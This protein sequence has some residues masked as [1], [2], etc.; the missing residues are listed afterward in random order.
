MRKQNSI[1]AIRICTILQDGMATIV[2][3]GKKHVPKPLDA[4]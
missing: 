1:A 2:A 3:R 4:V